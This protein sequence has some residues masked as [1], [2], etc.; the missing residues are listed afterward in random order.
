MW[1]RSF[2]VSFICRHPI[3]FREITVHGQV[4]TPDGQA[5]DVLFVGTTDGRVLK[6]VNTADPSN[7]RASGENVPTLVEEIVIFEP[8]TKVR[9]VNKLGL[10]L[11]ERGFSQHPLTVFWVYRVQRN[12]LEK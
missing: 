11:R 8:G 12:E 10:R 2:S 5:Y 7:H 3:Q 9:T 4:A 6:I 1:F